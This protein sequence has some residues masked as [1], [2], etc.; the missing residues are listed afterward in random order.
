MS[1]RDLISLALLGA[2]GLAAWRAWGATSS[3]ASAPQ[4]QPAS[5]I[6]QAKAQALAWTPADQV[7]AQART[8]GGGGQGLA[9]TVSGLLS[10][11]LGALGASPPPSGAQKAPPHPDTTPSTGGLALPSTT[12]TGANLGPLLDLIGNAEAPQGYAQVY[13]GSKIAPPRPI[14]QMTVGQVMAWQQ[15]SKDAGSASTAAGRYQIIL[16]TLESLV[17]D[18]TL[19]I[20]DTFGPATQDRAARALLDRRGLG[21]YRQGNLSLASFAQNLSQEW[22]SLPA[23]TRDA[24]GRKAQGQSY[25]AGDGLNRALV[26]QTAVQSALTQV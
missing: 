3:G 25:Y 8:A 22:A 11:L 24:Q 5:F 21:A 6:D 20:G 15:K 7:A 2:G 17:S 16:P 18:G 14:T 1:A 10:G 13:A 19:S 12:T 4:A 26:S 9:S 23:F